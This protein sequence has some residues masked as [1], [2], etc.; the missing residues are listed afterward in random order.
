MST[1]QSTP[2]ELSKGAA[3][4]SGCPMMHVEQAP[5]L[6]SLSKAE[7]TPSPAHRPSLSDISLLQLLKPQVL[8]D[9]YPLYRSMR[10]HK[11]VF[12][13]PYMH[14]WIVTG[15]AD[16]LTVLTKY[17]ADR[18]PTPQELERL[19]LGQMQPFAQLMVQQMLFMDGAAHSR[20]RTLCSAAFTPRSV[21]GLRSFIQEI[22]DGLIDNV[23]DSGRMD[24][25][26][27]FAAPLP[28]I[29]TAKLLGFP[30]EDHP[31][32][33]RWSAD[34]A[35]LLGNFQHNPDRIA[36]VTESLEHLSSYVRNKME[37]HRQE[38][39]GDGLLASLMGAEVDG[40]RLTDD[41]VLANTIVTMIGGQE[42]T[43]NLIGN[44]ML[45][46]LRNPEQL[47]LLRD[48]PDIIASAVEELLRFES[49]SQHT[50]RLAPA[51]IELSGER[52]TKGSAVMAI[53]AAANRDPVRFPNPDKL[54][55]LRPDNRHLA[56]GWAA[57]FCFGAPL[58]RLEAQL[59][60]S[61]VLRRLPELALAT[62]SLEWRTNTGLRGLVDLPLTFTSG[63]ATEAVARSGSTDGKRVPR[64]T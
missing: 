32:L 49:P 53:M 22:V 4:A 28:A 61:T 55:L 38:G 43:T 25:I 52:I 24:L 41:E 56:F 7:R 51:D 45:T 64:W 27:D 14:S 11:P 9:P 59:A 10:E 20:L 62:D 35:E 2:P 33:K 8:A 19:G 13:D 5:P 18:T 46:L 31:K 34:L 17:Q 57:H 54:D 39:S 23:V 60:F 42:T 44:G 30:T 1:T 36:E 21:E 29:V 16:V 6:E 58:A 37:Q 12:W 15:Y 63:T 50:G 47:A 40:G 3:L 48:S 26:A